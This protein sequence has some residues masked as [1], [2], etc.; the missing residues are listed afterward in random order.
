MFKILVLSVLVLIVAILMLGLKDLFNGDAE[1]LNQ[2]LK[3][4]V[5]LSLVLLLFII[6][7]YVSGAIE[8]SA[9]AAFI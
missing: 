4:R 8:V 7:A 6:M 5:G 9:Y 2:S 3:W 1:G